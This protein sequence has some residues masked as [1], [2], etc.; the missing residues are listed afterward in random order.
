M[1]K[2]FPILLAAAGLIGFPAYAIMDKGTYK[3][4]KDQIDATY[5]SDKAACA[6]LTGN[7]GDVCKAEA[8]AKRRTASAEA[9]A[10]YK[11]TPK[12]RTMA[13]VARADA[14]YS[15]TRT[16]CNEVS[17]TEKT[18]CITKAKAARVRAKAD[19]RANQEVIRK[20]DAD[21]AIAVERCDSMRSDAKDRCL[22]KAKAR[23]RKS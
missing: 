7:A 19:A 8:E 5:K 3:A 22:K 21:Y 11:N 1:S 4:A 2:L 6:S 23:L 10:D 15:V 20:R 17:G 18:V 16:R 14:E 12:A 9:E 13:I